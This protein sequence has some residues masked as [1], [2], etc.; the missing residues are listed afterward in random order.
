MN[1]DNP[2]S[3]HS[4]I[5]ITEFRNMITDLAKSINTAPK[6]YTIKEAAD[7]LKCNERAIRHHLYES[8]DLRYCKIAGKVRIR[9][10]DLAELIESKLIP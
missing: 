5:S 9:E 8:R 1:A 3:S 10:M 4:Q 7:I 6:I 2:N